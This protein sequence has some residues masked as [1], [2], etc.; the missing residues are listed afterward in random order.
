M[1][2]P[3]TSS[4]LVKRLK[5]VTDEFRSME[6]AASVLGPYCAWQIGDT[7]C[8]LQ[9]NAAS[10]TLCGTTIAE[11][12][13]AAQADYTARI[14]SAIDATTIERLTADLAAL[15]IESSKFAHGMDKA[16]EERDAAERRSEAFWKPQVEA[17][18]ALNARQAEALKDAVLDA[19]ERQYNG[20]AKPEYGDMINAVV[21]AFARALATESSK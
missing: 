11:A 7:G 16:R 12:K 1:T 14:L 4:G 18:S 2:N 21:A 3:E 8:Y 13:A 20:T 15:K 17:L 10:G 19:I 9:P 6:V 5:W